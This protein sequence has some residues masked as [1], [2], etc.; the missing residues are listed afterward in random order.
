MNPETVEILIVDDNEDD[1]L[2]IK[3]AI[4]AA[5][6]INVIQEVNDGEEAMD[7]LRHE[8]KFENARRPGLV[9]L[10]IN[11]PR[12]NGFEVLEA[13]KADDGLR[14]I[15]VVM[16]TTS[17]REEDVVKSYGNGACAFISKPTTFEKLKEAISH[18]SMFWT[19]TAK[20][21]PTTEQVVRKE[22][23]G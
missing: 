23:K 20:I 22:N 19:L 12:M 9:L 2:F 1:I 4:E 15:P 10:D 11:M 14:H 13:M 17:D 5:K 8:G 6:L 3:E 7:Y 16:L 18:F 21:P